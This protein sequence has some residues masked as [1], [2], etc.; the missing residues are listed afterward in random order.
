MCPSCAQD[1]RRR[2]QKNQD[3]PK[4][5][6]RGPGPPPSYLVQVSGIAPV[7]PSMVWSVV[8]LWS[9]EQPKGSQKPGSSPGADQKP[10]SS[11]GAAQKPGSSPGA[12]PKKEQPYNGQPR[13]AP[14]EAARTSAPLV[15]RQ[16]R[17]SFAVTTNPTKKHFP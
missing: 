3:I 12:A 17:E 14:L 16:C 1:N 5:T 8:F 2:A 4:T 7:H 6:L 9:Q 15:R 11:P 13:W 10:G